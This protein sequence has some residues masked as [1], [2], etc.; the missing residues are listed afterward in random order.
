VPLQWATTQNNLGNAL[1]ILGER[2][3]GTTRLEEAVTAFRTA[4]QERTRERMPFD[5]AMTQ[6]NLA[7]VFRSLATR[8]DGV[9]RWGYLTDALA[10]V[11]GALAVYREGDAAY[12]IEKAERLRT[13][14]LDDL[15]QAQ[16]P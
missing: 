1:R 14:I 13:M 9:A 11:D 7:L 4:L 6:E 12:Y 8:I 2:E 16:A 10:A 5:W 3:S 15:G